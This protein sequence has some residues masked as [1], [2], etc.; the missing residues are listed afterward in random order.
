MYTIISTLVVQA[1]PCLNVHIACFTAVS[2][3]LCE[4]GRARQSH[5]LLIS[6]L[7]HPSPLHRISVACF[8]P[9]P[10][11]T[12]VFC[13][14]HYR[15]LI[16]YISWYAL[17]LLRQSIGCCAIRLM[18]RC[19]FARIREE[20]RNSEESKNL[21]AIFLLISSLQI[22]SLPRIHLHTYTPL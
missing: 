11:P 10:F 18:Q 9:A 4:F 2:P 22:D 13:L 17:R 5:C 8:T 12:R 6:G 15:L 19:A 7:G 20:A 21:Q 16:D 14:K 1:G 3:E